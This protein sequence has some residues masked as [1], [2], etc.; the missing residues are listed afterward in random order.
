MS[1]KSVREAISLVFREDEKVLIFRRSSNRTTFPNCWSLPS[2]YIEEN[3]SI[4]D[5]AG[6]LVQSKL[7][8]GKVILKPEIVGESVV[9]DRGGLP[10][11]YDRCRS[12]VIRRNF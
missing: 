11:A 2:A 10:S 7:G 3:E 8:L 1:V 9:V 4:K 12:R 5:T 6:K